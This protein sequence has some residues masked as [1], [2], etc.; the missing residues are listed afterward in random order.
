VNDV[1]GFRA[2]C[3]E[4]TQQETSHYRARHSSEH[5]VTSSVSSATLLP[6]SP[7][8]SPLSPLSP[9]HRSATL[10]PLS[11]PLS[12]LSPL[13]PTHR[14]AT[15]LPLSPPLSPLLLLSTVHRQARHCCLCRLRC[16]L[17]CSYLQ[18][19]SKRD[20]VASVASICGSVIEIVCERHVKSISMI[21]SM[22]KQCKLIQ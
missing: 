8:L 13:S 11:P 4:P 5:T 6:L 22:A 21:Q 16:R 9:T 19:I 18:C 7:P 15:L 1:T 17:C 10:L 3:S 2:A 20:T 12:P 14:S